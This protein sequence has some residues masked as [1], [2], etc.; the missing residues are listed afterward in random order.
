MSLEGIVGPL[1]DPQHVFEKIDEF[2][3]RA[4]ETRVE[5]SRR[6]NH[7]CTKN[8]PTHRNAVEAVDMLH[9]SDGARG[10]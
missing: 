3:L 7:V 6:R 8:D 5:C 9:L 4:K 10:Q 1:V 2:W